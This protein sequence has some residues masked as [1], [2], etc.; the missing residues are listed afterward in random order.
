M[1][2]HQPTQHQPEIIDLTEEEM[3]QIERDIQIF[4]IREDLKTMY[5]PQ[6]TMLCKWLWQAAKK[7]PTFNPTDEE[8]ESVL[9]DYNLWNKLA[10]ITLEIEEDDIISVSS[11]M[12]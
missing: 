1:E 10:E 4:E 3:D 7:L 8:I 12:E 6:I 9:N 5:Q 2:Q 11:D